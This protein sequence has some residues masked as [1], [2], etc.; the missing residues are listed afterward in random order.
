MGIREGATCG[1][2]LPLAEAVVMVVMVGQVRLG[3]PGC[4]VLLGQAVVMAVDGGSRE[5]LP[6]GWWHGPV[7]PV[8]G[9]H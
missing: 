1:L 4:G 3:L 5:R 6:W 8:V 2:G 9:W 7:A